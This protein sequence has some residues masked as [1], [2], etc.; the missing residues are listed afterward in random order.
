[1]QMRLRKH[2]VKYTVVARVEASLTTARLAMTAWRRRN[3]TK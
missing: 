1:M 3:A 2:H